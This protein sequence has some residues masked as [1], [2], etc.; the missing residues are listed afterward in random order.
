[1]GGSSLGGDGLAGGWGNSRGRQGCWGGGH[2]SPRCG[3]L[4]CGFL[5]CSSR[6]GCF[7]GCG[8]QSR[9]LTENPAGKKKASG[10]KL[11][12]GDPG[13]GRPALRDGAK[14]VRVAHAAA[15]LM[16]GGA[17]LDARV[18]V[19]KLYVLALVVSR[20]GPKPAQPRFL[21]ALT[22]GGGAGC[23]W[24]W[25]G[26]RSGG[27]GICGGLSA[28]QVVQKKV[29]P[30][31]YPGPGVVHRAGSQTWGGTARAALRPG[32]PGRGRQRRRRPRLAGTASVVSFSIFL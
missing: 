28:A 6:G 26:V 20:G 27:G 24:G 22:V 30:E 10:K 31:R 23:G 4:G 1:M 9:W 13:C 16:A 25:G 8:S 32:L 2:G 5:G 15:S 17:V 19:P 18:T 29:R 7:L 11:A 21:R 3:F 12:H 14:P